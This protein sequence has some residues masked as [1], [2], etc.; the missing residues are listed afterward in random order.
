MSGAVWRDDR[1]GPR[2][3]AAATDS[4]P[5]PAVVTPRAQPAPPTGT[6]PTGQ[7]YERPSRNAICRQKSG[8]GITTQV[9]GRSS[10][11]HP[12]I[13]AI[14]DDGEVG[15]ERNAPYQPGLR[16][17]RRNGSAQVQVVP[18]DLGVVD[19]LGHEF[20]SDGEPSPAAGPVC[21]CGCGK[22]LPS[23]GKAGMQ[24]FNASHRAAASVRRRQAAASLS[25]LSMN[26]HRLG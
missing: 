24:Y 2:R 23:T 11:D 19:Y 17:H 13:P 12:D 14:R 20:F 8:R 7:L 16:V 9:L 18:V 6:I 15:W 4:F 10:P 5:W 26:L 21:R 3:V 25:A 22:L 1:N